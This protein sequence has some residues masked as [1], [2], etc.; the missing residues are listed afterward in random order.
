MLYEHLKYFLTLINLFI[1]YFDI[2]I[3]NIFLNRKI[4]NLTKIISK[5]FYTD[6]FIVQP[7]YSNHFYI[8]NMH[9][10][11][12]II[13]NMSHCVAYYVF[14]YLFCFLIDVVK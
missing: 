1:L 9:I 12:R 8:V 5:S 2:K 7:V 11:N 3:N 13:Y 4:T 14:T 6:L 10:I